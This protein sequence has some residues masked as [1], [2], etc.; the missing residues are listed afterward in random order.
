M[1]TQIIYR[2]VKT[3]LNTLKNVL[4]RNCVYKHV[5]SQSLELPMA[6]HL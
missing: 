4:L 1:C 3:E 5:V 2:L 6:R